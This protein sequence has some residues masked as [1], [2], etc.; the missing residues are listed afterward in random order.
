MGKVGM[1]KDRKDL[2]TDTPR[3]N[4]Q[5]MRLMWS[6]KI[7]NSGV[8]IISWILAIGLHFKHTPMYMTCTTETR[9]VELWDKP[10]KKTRDNY[11]L[12]NRTTKLTTR[13]TGHQVKRRTDY[14]AERGTIF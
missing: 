2:K 13:R 10:L 8:I 7:H 5:V 1:L 14:Q 6:N 12:Q 9:L 4:E 11:F 3:R